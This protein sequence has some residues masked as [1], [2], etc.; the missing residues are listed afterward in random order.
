MIRFEAT[1]AMTRDFCGE[2][3]RIFDPTASQFWDSPKCIDYDK[4]L[5]EKCKSGEGTHVEIYTDP[6]GSCTKF[7]VKGS[8]Q[9]RNTTCQQLWKMVI[10]RT[11]NN[12]IMNAFKTRGGAQI[13][14]AEEQ[15][16][17]DTHERGILAEVTTAMQ[18]AYIEQSGCKVQS[19][20]KLQKM[21][22]EMA[23]A[24]VKEGHLVLMNSLEKF[25]R[26]S[27]PR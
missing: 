23:K 20:R 13:I 6:I 4:Y 15:E 11:F 2:N 21:L 26:C 16:T 1:D 5:R 17:W 8:R 3:G 25:R 12:A 19:E 10:M 9:G 7:D 14:L 27:S 24:Q 22:R 18:A